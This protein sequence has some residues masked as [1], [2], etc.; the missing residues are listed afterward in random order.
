MKTITQLA[1][2]LGVSR[3]ALTKK[4]EVKMGMTLEKS[5]RSKVI[6][7]EQEILIKKDYGFIESDTQPS[8]E[9]M[10]PN[11]QPSE[12]LD[13]EPLESDTQPIINNDNDYSQPQL[14]MLDTLD[15]EDVEVYKVDE[16]LSLKKFSKKRILL[17]AL[18]LLL[19]IS[20]S[21]GG[22]FILSNN[23]ISFVGTG[24]INDDSFVEREFRQE[25]E[26][27]KEVEKEKEE[28]ETPDVPVQ[29][30][31][32]PTPAP[33]VQTPPPVQQQ[34]APAPSRP[35]PSPSP[36]P[37]PAPSRPAPT[38]AP[39]PPPAS[40]GNQNIMTCTQARQQQ[41]ALGQQGKA[42]SVAEIGGGNCV[43]TIHN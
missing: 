34:P 3:Q 4:I 11:T 40:N 15:D 2:E 38:P 10:Q 31:P 12:T 1:N 42:T 27:K 5:G 17:I 28:Q 35:A 30:A 36:A 37:S 13:T 14:F 41:L 7:E 33:P 20:G 26:E 19:L 22:W 21:V 39:S 29:Q 9:V 24:N 16:D 18:V 8:N 32:Q 6:S 43:L 25:E 23:Q